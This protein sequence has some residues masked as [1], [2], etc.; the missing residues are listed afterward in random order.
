MRAIAFGSVL[1]RYM[2]ILPGL[3]PDNVLADKTLYRIR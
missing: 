1:Y 2:N 3:E